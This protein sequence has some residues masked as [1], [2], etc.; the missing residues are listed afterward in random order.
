MLQGDGPDVYAHFLA[1][2]Q[3]EIG[4]Y[5]AFLLHLERNSGILTHLLPRT[6]ILPLPY[7]TITPNIDILHHIYA[8]SSAMSVLVDVGQCILW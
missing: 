3:I 8:F 6:W 7:R 5:S 1:G 2:Q 4:A